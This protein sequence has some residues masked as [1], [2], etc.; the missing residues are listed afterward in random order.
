[1]SDHH[2]WRLLPRQPV[3]VVLLALVVVVLAAVGMV[4]ILEGTLTSSGSGAVGTPQGHSVGLPEPTSTLTAQQ[5]RPVHN[6]LHD[7]GRACRRRPG[8]AHSEVLRA[9]RVIA[10]F[11]KAHP[12]ARFPIDD[13][14]GSSMTLLF[15]VRDELLSCAPS[16]VTRVD[17]LIPTEY[18]P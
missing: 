5:A 11:A 17:R 7:L 12:R 14:S 15:V 18:R 8:P 9:L 4:R 3:P 1:M 16:L 13:E 2:A 6:A 10:D